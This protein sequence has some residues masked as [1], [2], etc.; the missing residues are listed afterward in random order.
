QVDVNHQI[1]QLRL[2]IGQG[3]VTGNSGIMYNNIQTAMLSCRCL[4]LLTCIC[5]CNI[6]SQGRTGNLTGYAIKVSLLLWNIQTDDMCAI[7]CQ[8]MAIASP[9]PR[10]APVTTAVLPA[11]GLVQSTSTFSADKTRIT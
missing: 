6:N 8:Y 5:S 2:H 9:I 7:T 4:N 11:N 1:P 3:L 10:L